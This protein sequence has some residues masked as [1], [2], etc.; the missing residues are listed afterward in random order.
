MYKK[1]LV[2][3][4][5]SQRAEAILPHVENLAYCTGAQLILLTIADPPM[6]LVSPYD[7]MPS[8]TAEEIEIMVE[9]AEAY[10]QSVAQRIN[11]SGIGTQTVVEYGA[12]VAAII[13]VAERERADLVAMASHGRTGLARVFYGSVAAGVLQRIDRPLLLIRA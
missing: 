10:L 4:D 5:G 12:V 9:E 11:A 8:Y 13:E 1:I 3:L 2:P 6:N 7:M